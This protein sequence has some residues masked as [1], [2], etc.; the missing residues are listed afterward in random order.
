MSGQLQ[1]GAARRHAVPIVAPASGLPLIKNTVSLGRRLEWRRGR[2]TVDADMPEGARKTKVYQD[3]QIFIE[4]MKKEDGAHYRNEV[5]IEGPFPHHEIRR[6]DVQVGDR[7]GRRE[8]ARSLEQD[9]KD[10]GKEDYII[11]ALFDV[12]EMITEIPTSL[13]LDL[14]TQPGKLRSDIRPLREKDWRG[15]I[16]NGSR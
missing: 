8:V 11:H 5:H 4:W 9:T 10:T 6:N 12:P 2:S 14:F 15:V 7:G 3:F 16:R 13:A 1:L